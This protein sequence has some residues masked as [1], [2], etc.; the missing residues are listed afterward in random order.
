MAY[1]P[2]DM[3]SNEDD[4][5]MQLWTQVSQLRREACKIKGLSGFEP[6]TSQ[7]QIT[8]I[9]FQ[10][11]SLPSK[12]SLQRELSLSGD[13]VVAAVFVVAWWTDK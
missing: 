5:H 1:W 3:K 6:V 8:A 11:A 7:N 12:T 2:M 10:F 13:V 9:N 4:R